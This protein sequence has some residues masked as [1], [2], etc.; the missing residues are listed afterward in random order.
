[1]NTSPSL[2]LSQ[3]AGLLQRYLRPLKRL[4]LG[5]AAL[6][7]AGIALQLILPLVMRRFID[8]V[9]AGSEISFLI[10]LGVVYLLA[11]VLQQA[12]NVGATYLSENVGWSATNALRTDLAD[13]LLHMDLSFHNAHPAGE[14]IERIDGDITALSNFFSRF[15]VK[16]LGN[17]V[18][19]TGVLVVLFSVDWR[20]GAAIAVFLGL[21][22]FLLLRFRDL[23]GPYYKQERQASAELFGFIEER[24]AGVEDVRANG[25]QAYVMNRFYELMRTLLQRALKAAQIINVML[26][27]SLF[28]FAAGIAA[29]FAVGAYLFLRDEI[30]LGTVYLVY[31]YTLM[32]Q[33][34]IEEIVHQ[35]QDFQKAGAGAARVTE[36]LSLKSTL[37]SDAQPA[38]LAYGGKQAWGENTGTAIAIQFDHVTFSYPDAAPRIKTE[39]GDADDGKIEAGTAVPG[40]DP[41]PHAGPQPIDHLPGEIILD[42]LSFHLPAGKILGLLGRT[43]SGKTTLTRLLFRLYDPLSGAI[44]I[45]ANHPVSHQTSYTQSPVPGRLP[46]E[47]VIQAAY[48]PDAS[49]LEVPVP[50]FTDLRYLPLGKL[51]QVIGMIPQSVQLFNAP[52][53]DN[54]T[55]FDRSIRDTDVLAAIEALGLGEWLAALPEGLNTTLESGGG[56]LSAGQAQLLAFARIFLR[57][58]GLVILDEASSRLDPATEAWVET[59]IDRLVQHRTAVIVAHRLSTVQRADVIMILEGGRIVEYGDRLALAADPGSR[60][61]HLLETGMEEVLA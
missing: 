3:Y 59:A 12:A 11:A 14:L 57:R 44:R 7:L 22:L 55:F 51:R 43:G 52:V 17:L 37:T 54:L 29:A 21:T 35:V 6:I 61:H 41:L 39:P 38:Y 32:L 9:Q 1:M 15:T 49:G 28:M 27:T 40:A 13:H 4:V 2:T 5:M 19:M 50:D 56:G 8:S 36:L 58:P 18:M 26:N 23:A 10:Q 16:L 24:L 45:A 34:P 47:P 53:R 60:F 25:G 30:S 46:G 48:P 42:D 20:V 33:L 31:Q